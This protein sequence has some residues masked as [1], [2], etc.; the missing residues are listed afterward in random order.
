MYRFLWNTP[1]KYEPVVKTANIDMVVND[2]V[3]NVK[4]K[5]TEDV[6]DDNKTYYSQDENGEEEEVQSGQEEEEKSHENKNLEDHLEEEFSQMKGEDI[7]SVAPL[8]VER[9]ELLTE[10][11]KP[12]ES[13]VSFFYRMKTCIFGC[14]SSVEAVAPK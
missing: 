4:D 5:K 12:Q 6:E 10:Q 7:V 2:V 13:S 11:K 3:V 9:D 1:K 8:K 14:T